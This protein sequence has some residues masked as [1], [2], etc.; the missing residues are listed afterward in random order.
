MGRRNAIADQPFRRGY[1]VNMAPPDA[2][3]E[4]ETPTTPAPERMSPIYP[5]RGGFGGYNGGGFGDVGVTGPGGGLRRGGF[6][7]AGRIGAPV[8]GQGG[9]SP[10][11]GGEVDP[12]MA[13]QMRNLMGRRGGIGPRMM[14]QQM[15]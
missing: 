12:A 6:R 4:G 10:M 2:T 14:N 3:A 5:N 7:D 11:T 13:E 1:N 15:Y 9:E 8:M